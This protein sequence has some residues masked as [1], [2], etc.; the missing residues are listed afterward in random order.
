MNCIQTNLPGVLILEPAV[1][2]DERGFFLESYHHDELQKMGIK[3]TFVQ[4]NHSRSRRGV[5]RGLHFQLNSPQAKLC[6][7]ARGKVLDVAV[8]IRTGSPTF[9]QWTSAIL[10]DENHHML[11]VPR[12]FAHG[13]YV[14]SE[15][16]DFL[17]KCDDYYAPQ[18]QCGIRW[19]DPKL[20]INWQIP[21]RENPIVNARDNAYL[22]LNE[23][24]VAELPQY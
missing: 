20:G 10:S 5:L 22:A 8:D 19:N 13:F 14:L 2:H 16:V 4:D 23:I 21:D 24:N 18:D 3:S 1:F 11:F 15:E 6:R 7:V 12:G 17:Y 9:G